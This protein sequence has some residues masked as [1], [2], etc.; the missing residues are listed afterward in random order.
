MRLRLFWKIL[1]GFWVTFICIMEGTWLVFALYGPN[2]TRLERAGERARSQVTMLAVAARYGGERGLQEALQSWHA[3][4]RP[5]INVERLPD[6]AVRIDGASG[7]EMASNKTGDVVATI[8]A[9]DHSSFRLTYDLSRI[10]ARMQ[11]PGPFDVPWEFVL[12]G[13]M[14]GLG[15]SAALAWYLSQP[16]QRL[17]RGFDQLAGGDLGVRLEPAMGRRRD[18]IADLARDFD[19]MAARLQQLVAARE[20]LL[21]DVSHEL[22]SPLARL[23]V[24]IGLARQN[25]QRLAATLDRVEAEAERLDELVGEVLTLSRAESGVPQHDDYFD[26]EGLVRKVAEDAQFEAQA[27]GVRITVEEAARGG[28]V[29]PVIRGNAELIRR[30]LENIVRNALHHSQGGQVVTVGIAPDHA[31]RQFVIRVADQ[32]P[33]VAP[34]ALSKIFDPFVRVDHD[35]AGRIVGTTTGF[36]LGLAIARRAVLAH[37]GSIEARNGVQKGLIVIIRLPFNPRPVDVAELD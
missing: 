22:R 29:D 2:Q 15:F 14:G 17:R 4:D 7:F 10:R 5:Y 13:L 31:A 19:V 34:E 32:G 8:S 25:P 12:L 9:A 20:Q 35:A 36:G 24:A 30:A 37:D 21:H 26:L 6:D 18:E 33:G 16:I 28:E 1:I 27:S 23:Q 11:P 3:D